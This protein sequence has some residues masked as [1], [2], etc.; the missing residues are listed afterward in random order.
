MLLKKKYAVILGLASSVA[1]GVAALP[2]T[3][4][5]YKNLKVLPKNISSKD[6]TRIMIDDFEDGLGVSCTFCHVEGKDSLGLDYAN[7]AKPEKEIARRMMKM[8]M[9]IN[10]K[11]FGLKHPLLGDSVL[12]IN[13]ITCHNGQPRP[14]DVETK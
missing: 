12:A 9:G 5:D 13:C 2:S 14:G 10:E 11:Y 3:N 1:I 4:N 8:T 6:L 7:D